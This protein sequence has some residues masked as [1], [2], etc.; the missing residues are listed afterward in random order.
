MVR[1]PHDNTSLCQRVNY[2]E[3]IFDKLVNTFIK[4][5]PMKAGASLYIMRKLITY[6]FRLMTET[7]IQQPSG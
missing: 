7:S 3:K 4:T 1:E 6:K 5:S 2:V